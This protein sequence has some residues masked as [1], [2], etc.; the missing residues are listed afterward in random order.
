MPP[1]YHHTQGPAFQETDNDVK[2]QRTKN[3]YQE[4]M[5]RNTTENKLLSENFLLLVTFWDMNSMI[6]S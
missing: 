3:I 1:E 4:K 2:Q 6:V 5:S